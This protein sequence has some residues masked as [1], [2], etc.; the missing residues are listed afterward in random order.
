MENEKIAL[1]FDMD[2]TIVSTDTIFS[3]F[4]EFGKKEKGEEIYEWSKN[5]PK[6]VA[7]LYN[8]P[9]EEIYPGMDV[10]LI[11]KE[12]I[13]EN[14]GI[15]LNKFEEL[16][17]A[18]PIYEGAEKFFSDFMRKYGNNVFIISS[19]FE[20]IAR[21]IAKK[22]GIPIE[23]VIATKLLKENEKITKFIGPVLEAEK[24]ED[25]LKEITTKNNILLKN[26]VGVGDGKHDHFFIKAIT[27]SG[28]L[29][30][31]VSKDKTLI[32]NSG[33]QVIMSIPDY[34]KISTA[35][36]DFAEKLEK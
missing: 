31:A 7:D 30:I 1:F 26:C 24:K 34:T 33:A 20:P 2:E 6:K 36:N 27:A 28:G 10:E 19:S 35:V 9:I 11:C 18:L 32:E 16:V 3:L 15:P 22:L 21:G 23:N 14:K 8:I 5:N 4:D 25:A 12:I 29:G 13:E 17:N